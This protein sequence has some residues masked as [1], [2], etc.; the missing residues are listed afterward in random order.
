MLN[1]VK[2]QDIFTI[3]PTPYLWLEMN[4]QA[5]SQNLMLVILV[6]NVHFKRFANECTWSWKF[7][8]FIPY[9]DCHIELRK[10]LH[11]QEAC[12]SYD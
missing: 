10:F 12:V 1:S 4:T 9:E 7:K 8:D 11:Q 6:K 3:S 2:I 5:F